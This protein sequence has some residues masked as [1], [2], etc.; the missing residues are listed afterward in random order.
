MAD[1]HSHA[2][3]DSHNRS[4][5]PMLHLLREASVDKAVAEFP[6]AKAI[7]QKNIETMRRLGIAGWVTLG[8]DLPSGRKRKR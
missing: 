8:L 6:E 5:Y 3:S 1:E 2:R 7:Y 4:P